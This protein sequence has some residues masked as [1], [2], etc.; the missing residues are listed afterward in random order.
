MKKVFDKVNICLERYIGGEAFFD[1]LD[2][3][4]KFDKEVLVEFIDTTQ[5]QFKEV[6]TIA[7]GGGVRSMSP[8]LWLSGR[9]TG[10]RWI[11]K[12]QSNL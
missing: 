5:E 1:E 11:K 3:M 10:S 8:Q 4:V 6:H 2:K 12:R 7:S 9:L